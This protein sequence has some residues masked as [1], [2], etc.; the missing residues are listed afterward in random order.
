MA[1]RKKKI[2]ITGAAGFVGL[3]LIEQL[4]NINHQLFLTTRKKKFTAPG[5]KVY[6]GK[7]EDRQF[8]QKILKDIDEVYYLAGYKKNIAYHTKYPFEF[9]DGN[10]KPLMQF[11][12]ALGKSKVKKVVYL[13]SAIVNY[14]EA[15]GSNDGYIL[16]KYANEVAIKAFNQQSKIPVVIVR[17]AAIYGPGDNFEPKTANFIPAI[18]DRI[19]KS[20]NSLTIWGKGIR[21]MQ[22]VYIDDLVSNLLAAMRGKKLLYIVGNAKSYTVNQVVAKILKIC[23]KPLKIEHDLSKP[24]KPTNKIIF[25]NAVKPKVNLEKGLEKAVDYYIQ[26]YV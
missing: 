16:G 4:R 14:M 2:L 20:N 19:S 21:K 22:F 11:L 6:Y 5:V 24:D 13:S 15:Q 7:L 1:R 10:V 25:K 8:C 23:G 12:A 26:K 17:S 3:H 9:F 18:I